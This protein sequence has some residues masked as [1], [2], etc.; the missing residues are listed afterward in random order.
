MKRLGWIVAAVMSVALGYGFTAGNGFGAEG[1]QL[2]ELAW[3][4]VT[5][6]DLYLMLAVFASWVWSRESS[7]LR[8]GLWTLALA[9]LGSL[10]AGAYLVVA[11][12]QERRR[13]GSD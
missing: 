6:I 11:A 8:A 5:I 2:L 10:A 4:R 7:R 3:G 1:S 9:T 13:M 12:T